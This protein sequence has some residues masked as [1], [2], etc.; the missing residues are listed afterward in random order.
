L[1]DIRKKAGSYQ[2][3]KKKESGKGKEV[4]KHK[5]DQIRKQLKKL[6]VNVTIW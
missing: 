1:A 3:Q 2:T 4:L 6:K 5:D